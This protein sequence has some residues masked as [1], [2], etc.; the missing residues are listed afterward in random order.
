MSVG[1]AHRSQAL[2]LAVWWCVAV[3]CGGG[4]AEP[5]AAAPAD[6]TG[7]WRLFVDDLEIE[8][9]SGTVRRYHQFSKYPG[10]PVLTNAR[11]R[12]ASYILTVQRGF[13]RTMAASS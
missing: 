1:T 4:G 8:N 5:P 3:A 6:L 2:I 13:V 12:S 11:V 10:N 9:R 7:P